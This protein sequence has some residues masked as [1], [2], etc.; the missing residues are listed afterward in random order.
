MIG[1][2]SAINLFQLQARHSGFDCAKTYLIV[3]EEKAISSVGLVSV[4]TSA[5]VFKPFTR[6]G[7]SDLSFAA[8]ASA[9]KHPVTNQIFGSCSLMLAPLTISRDG[10]MQNRPAARHAAA[11]FGIGCPAWQLDR[12][13]QPK[14]NMCI[15]YPTDDLPHRAHPVRWKISNE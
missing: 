15:Q 10:S 3:W 12:Y 14:F 9:W 2:A 1:V 11:R 6:N 5:A 13:T 7:Q 8:K 4:F